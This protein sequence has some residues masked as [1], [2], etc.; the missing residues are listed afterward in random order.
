[1]FQTAETDIEPTEQQKAVAEIYLKQN[2]LMEALESWVVFSDRRLTPQMK[3]LAQLVRTT[4][5]LNNEYLVYRG[6]HRT[7]IQEKMGF[8]DHKPAVGDVR[9]FC[10]GEKSISFTTDKAIADAFGSIVV[11]STLNANRQQFLVMTDSL[12][13][14]LAIKKGQLKFKSQKEVV[15][16]PPFRIEIK[17]EKVTTVPIFEKW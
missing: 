1:M 11:S 4:E 3:E 16:L 12:M 9:E 2:E 6:F 10:D 5:Q 13:A 8:H 14:G 17:Y 7:G 15:L